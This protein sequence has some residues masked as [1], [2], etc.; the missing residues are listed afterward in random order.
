MPYKYAMNPRRSANYAALRQDEVVVPYL[1]IFQRLAR[2]TM[3][4]VNLGSGDAGSKDKLLIRLR[5]DKHDS[6][7][8]NK[9][10]DEEIYKETTFQPPFP[11]KSQ[12]F[13]PVPYSFRGETRFV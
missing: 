3:A 5:H 7:H 9:Q 6:N 13:L 11:S 10:H 4:E 2:V 8:T 1:C 12:N